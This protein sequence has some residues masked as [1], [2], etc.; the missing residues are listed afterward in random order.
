MYFLHNEGSNSYSRTQFHL[1]DM[2]QESYSN[3]IHHWKNESDI[4]RDPRS[5]NLNTKLVEEQAEI[6]NLPSYPI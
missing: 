1:F 2:Y 4:D 5:E 6:D 3:T